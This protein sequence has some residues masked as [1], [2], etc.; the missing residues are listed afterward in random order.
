MIVGHIGLA[1]LS[2]YTDEQKLLIYRQD[3]QLNA[4]ILTAIDHG[5]S[6]DLTLVGGPGIFTEVK[7]T[8][9]EQGAVQITSQAKLSTPGCPI[10]L[11]PDTKI[12]TPDGQIAVKDLIVGARV[13]TVNR[14]GMRVS[15]VIVE[16]V[17]RPV[18]PNYPIVHLPLERWPRIVRIRQSS[19]G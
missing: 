6:F 15:S 3:K 10:C 1:N 12:D 17:K 16:T 7:G 11:L 5:Y 4:F 13:W 14:D 18:P 19:H 8:I 9:S 2:E